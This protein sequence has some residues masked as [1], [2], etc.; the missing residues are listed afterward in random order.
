MQRRTYT[1]P[2]MQAV[3]ADYLPVHIKIMLRMGFSFGY[4]R[5]REEQFRPTFGYGRNGKKVVSVGL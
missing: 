2:Q 3:V 1:P 4:G 5:N